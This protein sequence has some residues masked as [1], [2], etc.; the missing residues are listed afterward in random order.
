MATETIASEFNRDLP[1]YKTCPKLLIGQK[2]VVTGSSAG[3]GK[4]VAEGLAR[5]G[6]EVVINYAHDAA[7]AQAAAKAIENE[8]RKAIIFKPMSRSP[9]KSNR[10]SNRRCR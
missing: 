3:I 1:D 8:G 2:A 9:T 10:C 4:A 6:A 7:G 5:A